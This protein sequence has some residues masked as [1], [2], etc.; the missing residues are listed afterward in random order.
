MATHWRLV[1]RCG[2]IGAGVGLLPG[3]GASVSQWIAYA[4]AARSTVST[5]PFGTGAVEGVLGPASAN[6][7]TLGGALV[8]TLALGVP[9]SLSSAMLLSALVVKGLQPGPNM[10]LPESAGGHLGLVISLVWL[11]V[12]GNVLAVGLCLASSG[13]LLRV[14]RVPGQLLVP[15]ILMLTVLGAFA[16]K[17]AF[18][19]FS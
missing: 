7:A 16:A 12:L 13:L 9:A 2:A 5:R 4:H 14:T 6:N 15:F 18:G 10:L 8:P 1:L 19:T 11:M 17:N 3:T